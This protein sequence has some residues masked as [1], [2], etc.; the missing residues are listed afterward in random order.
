[1]NSKQVEELDPYGVLSK[2]IHDSELLDKI[3]EHYEL[4]SHETFANRGLDSLESI[5]K[6][7]YR[8]LLK[9]LISGKFQVIDEAGINHTSDFKRIIAKFPTL[10]ILLDDTSK[11][12]NNHNQKVTHEIE[13]L[14]FKTYGVIAIF[15]IVFYLKY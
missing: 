8:G 13:S 14:T 10:Y 4:N 1:M 11:I 6:E 5:L 15:L 12:L 2:Q 3:L 7:N 9:F